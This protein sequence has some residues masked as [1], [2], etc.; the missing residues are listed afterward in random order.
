MG[1][2]TLAGQDVRKQKARRNLELRGQWLGN[3]RKQKHVIR[4]LCATKDVPKKACVWQQA[5]HPQ[6]FEKFPKTER[7]D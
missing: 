1:N 2:N 3:G 6:S 4:T 5:L 7:K